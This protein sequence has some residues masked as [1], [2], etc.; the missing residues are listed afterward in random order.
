[1]AEKKVMTSRFIVA[2]LIALSLSLLAAPA[3]S[4]E[5]NINVGYQP[6][7]SPRFFVAK[8]E[9]MFEKAGL[10][11]NYI[12]F[13]TGP[14]MLAA[15]R[16]KDIDVAFM[17]T[18]PVIFGLSQGLDLKVFFIESD[19]AETQALVAIPNGAIK[20]FAD[21]QGR[22]IG[23]TFGSSAHY[24][25]LKSLQEANLNPGSVIILDMQPGTI[26][27]AFIRNDVDGAWCWDPWTAK[28]ES[29]NGRLI[30]SLGSM[31]LPMPGVWVARAE[32]LSREE[33]KVQRFIKAM[34]LASEL[35]LT[36]QTGA[37]AAIGEQLGVDEA[38]ATRIFD[39]I[40]RPSLATQIFGYGYEAALGTTRTKASSGMASHMNDVAEFFYSRKQIP[41]KPDVVSAIEPEPLERYLAAKK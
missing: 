26:L 38:V 22:R 39:R 2:A 14:A 37:I 30:G 3:L 27:P 17:T 31:H 20:S 18:P 15:L 24:A 13:T 34:E 29:E 19:A 32:W 33:E 28:M 40:E 41:V 8:N 6:G 25:L 4:D 23:V 12:K 9:K 1:M 16:G 21:Q 10:A 5:L 36:D 7:T 35:L 11:P